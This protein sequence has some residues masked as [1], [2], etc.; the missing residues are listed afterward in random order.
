MGPV[1]NDQPF[2]VKVELRL[3]QM[4]RTWYTETNKAVPKT[5]TA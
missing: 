4:I 2:A 3:A 5:S 1:G